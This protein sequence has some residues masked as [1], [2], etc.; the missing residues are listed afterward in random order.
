MVAASP[1][2]DRFR[3]IWRA[4]AASVVPEATQLGAAQWAEVEAIVTRALAARPARTQRQVA[5]FLT[6]LDWLPLVRYGRRL[7]ALDA[8]RRARVLSLLERAPSLLIR[9]GFWGVRTLVLL[10]YYGRPAAAATIG[11]RADPRG[12]D[13][14]ERAD[15]A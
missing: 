11:Y 13:A 9:R 2:T 15:G 12:W 1:A 7:R 3:P 10:G 5:L 4:V 14:R 6:L 8:A